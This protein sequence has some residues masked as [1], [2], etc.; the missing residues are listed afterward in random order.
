MSAV[1]LTYDDFVRLLHRDITHGRL[2]HWRRPDAV[3]V[4]PETWD[5]VRLSQWSPITYWTVEQ[6]HR[7]EVGGVR[8]VE[9]PAVPVGSI[10]TDRERM[11]SVLLRYECGEYAQI[12]RDGVAAALP[13]LHLPPKQIVRQVGPDPGT[14]RTVDL[15]GVQMWVTSEALERPAFGGYWE[16][17]RYVEEEL[18]QQMRALEVPEHVVDKV[19]IRWDWMPD[20]GADITRGRDGSGRDLWHVRPTVQ[21]VQFLDDEVWHGSTVGNEPVTNWGLR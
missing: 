7:S 18:R 3:R 4:H 19:G 11:P 9:D 8:V 13:W 15:S 6:A 14:K 10:V 16:M 17:R 1:T 21:A 20:V 12:V 5:D 2:D